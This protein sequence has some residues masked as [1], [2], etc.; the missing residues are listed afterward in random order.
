MNERLEQLQVAVRAAE[1][2]GD[3]LARACSAAS[4]ETVLERV[5]GQ[6]EARAKGGGAPAPAKRSR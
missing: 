3:E 2:A 6:F 1:A 4:V 5:I